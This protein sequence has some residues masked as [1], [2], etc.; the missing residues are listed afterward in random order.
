MVRMWTSILHYSTILI[1]CVQAISGQGVDRHLLGLKLTALESGRNI[2]ELHLDAAFTESSYFR[3]STSQ[4]CVC[5]CVCVYDC[6]HVN[7][8]MV[9]CVCV[10]LYVS[11]CVMCGLLCLC[12]VC[13]CVN[14]F[15]CAVF[16][17]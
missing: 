12:V 16:L 8:C 11:V 3:L 6:V 5:L 9:V 7:V 10:W 1:H 4:V 17:K 2:P 13:V 15:L 14:V